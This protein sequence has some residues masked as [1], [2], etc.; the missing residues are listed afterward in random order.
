MRCLSI[1]TWCVNCQHTHDRYISKRVN[2]QSPL[3]NYLTN[4]P[5]K[6]PNYCVTPRGR[7]FLVKQS[8]RRPVS[9]FPT[10]MYC[11]QLQTTAR[12]VALSQITSA[13]VLPSSFKFDFIEFPHLCLGLL[14][15][16]PPPRFHTRTPL[17]LRHPNNT[18]LKKARL[19]V[20]AA[21]W[22]MLPFFWDIKP[23]QRVISSGHFETTMSSRNSVN[24]TGSYPKKMETSAPT[25]CIDMESQRPYLLTPWS[26]VL[27]EKL[28]SK[29][30]S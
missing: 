17:W 19:K 29:L 9:K 7:L 10:N 14:I 22:L 26:R 13:H 5:T 21:M 2:F 28:T 3:P 1:P 30:C 20:F 6:Q 11:P 24:D 16:L 18:A 12:H 25:V 15:G 4:Q 8:V 23:G 27:L